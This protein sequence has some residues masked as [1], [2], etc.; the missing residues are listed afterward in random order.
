MSTQLDRKTPA[1]RTRNRRAF[2]RKART[3]VAATVTVVVALGAGFGAWWHF[4]DGRTTIMTMLKPA[5]TPA[6]ERIAASVTD[7]AYSSAPGFLAKTNGDA[8]GNVNYSPT[9]L[10]M[11]LALAAQGS[12]GATRG[13]LDEALGSAK[14]TDDD[15]RSLIRSV[16]GRYDDSKSTMELHDSVWIDKEYRLMDSYENAAKDTFD[17]EVNSLDMDR[18]AAERMGRWVADNTHGM[19]RP[20]IELDEDTILTIIDTVY[21]DGRWE[22]PFEPEDTM[23]DTFHGVTDESEVPMMMRSFD[24]LD[25]AEASDGSWRRASIPFDNGGALTILLPERAAFDEIAGDPDLL[26]EAMTADAAQAEVAM[27]LP[28]FTVDGT[29]ASDTIMGVLRGLGVEDAFSSDDADFSRMVEQDGLPGNP[30]IGEVIQGTRI[31]VNE[32][33]AKTA[34]FTQMNVDAAGAPAEEK[35]VD[36]TVDRPFLYE[37]STPDGV[38]L[39]VGAVRNL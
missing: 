34:A 29:F 17:A 14:F 9:S 30:F 4:G 8:H 22:S 12:D 35:W 37:L 10:W 18:H 13:Q 15:Y 7:F 33:G 21:A 1:G 31:E 32:H 23:D 39:F 3:I 27:T 11:A 6:T 20:D 25:Y 26:R 28:R 38:P 2:S 24:G 16:N 36:F 5:A 19:L